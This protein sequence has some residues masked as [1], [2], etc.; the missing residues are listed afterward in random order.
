MCCVDEEEE[1]E[2]RQRRFRHLLAARVLQRRPIKHATPFK[3]LAT[4]CALGT[5]KGAGH[6]G[7]AAGEARTHAL[8]RRYYETD[9]PLSTAEEGERM[10]SI[11][12]GSYPRLLSSALA[13]GRADHVINGTGR[14]ENIHRHKWSRHV[15][16]RKGRLHDEKRRRKPP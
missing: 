12:M 15:G 13:C 9:P 7:V 2:S 6:R 5:L 11:K 10:L 8:R 1:G 3:Q 4:L 16:S 14:Y